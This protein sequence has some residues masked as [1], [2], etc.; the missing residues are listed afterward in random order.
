LITLN[1]RENLLKV[2]K[3]IKNYVFIILLK[4]IQILCLTVKLK[5]KFYF[6][7]HILTTHPDNAHFHF[8]SK[9]CIYQR[10]KSEMYYSIYIYSWRRLCHALRKMIFLYI[11]EVKILWYWVFAIYDID[12][13]Q[14]RI[15]FVIKSKILFC[16]FKKKTDN[17]FLV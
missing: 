6:Y 8:G 9:L 11:I 7:F 3:D 14:W 13:L 17:L 1:D 10:E 12:Y 16:V 5:P 4:I 2:T 15:K